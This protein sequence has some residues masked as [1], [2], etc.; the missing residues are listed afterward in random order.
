MMYSRCFLGGFTNGYLSRDDAEWRATSTRY[1]SWVCN[2]KHPFS[3]CFLDQL[4]VILAML[5]R[6]GRRLAA[7][8][9]FC[10]HCNV[11]TVAT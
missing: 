8:L 10:E 9:G 4:V 11:N 3:L 6:C 5:F 7:F 1:V 2:L